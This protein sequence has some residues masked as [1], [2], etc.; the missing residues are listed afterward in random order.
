[1]DKND[2]VKYTLCWPKTNWNISLQ[3]FYAITVVNILKQWPG[4]LFSH[5]YAEFSKNFMCLNK[6]LW[7]S[8]KLNWDI[9]TWLEFLL[10]FCLRILLL[11][12][13]T[14]L[15]KWSQHNFD[16]ILGGFEQLISEEIVTVNS[17]RL[18]FSRSIAQFFTQ[19][20]MIFFS[21]FISWTN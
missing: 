11:I 14:E 18:F 4:Q 2:V 13:P 21:H 16:Q 17:Y 10:H 12:N 7:V 5:R 20:Y 15:K 6:K 9:L 19:I 3:D 1:M 8:I